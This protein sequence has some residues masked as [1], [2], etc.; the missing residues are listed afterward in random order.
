MSYAAKEI[1]RLGGRAV[2][3]HGMVADN[4]RILVGLSGGKDSLTMLN[5]L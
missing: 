1:Q 5:F 3:K 2:H 4:D